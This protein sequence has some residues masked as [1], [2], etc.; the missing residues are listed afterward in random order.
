VLVFP[1]LNTGNIAYKRTERLERAIALGPILQGLSKP[2]NDLS[3]GCRAE[4]VVD[5]IA[6]TAVQANGC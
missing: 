4:D 1:Y 5:V 3:R 6:I 2:V